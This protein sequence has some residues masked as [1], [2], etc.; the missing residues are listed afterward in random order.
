MSKIVD[1][2]GLACPQPVIVTRDALR[3]AEAVTTLVDDDTPRIN[4]TRL[5]GLTTT[6][7]G[8]VGQG[9]DKDAPGIVRGDSETWR[10]MP[11][12]IAAQSHFEVNRLRLTVGKQTLL[13]AIIMGDQTLSG[14][15]YHLVANRI[16]ITPIR[17][18]LLNPKTHLADLLADFWTSWREQHGAS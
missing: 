17:E 2:R 14:P 13:G 9:S 4:V 16:E 6:I 10:Q 15:L 18:Q 3:E 1:A 8:A 7:I 5:A 12:S 11:D